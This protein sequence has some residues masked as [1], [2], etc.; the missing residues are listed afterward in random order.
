MPD[1]GPGGGGV[2]VPVGGVGMPLGGVGCPSGDIGAPGGALV[3][4]SVPAWVETGD[5]C[6]LGS[7]AGDAPEPQAEAHKRTETA[8]TKQT[9]MAAPSCNKRAGWGTIH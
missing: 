7:W 4:G 6:W 8:E 3:T 9:F 5:G 1:A 2:G